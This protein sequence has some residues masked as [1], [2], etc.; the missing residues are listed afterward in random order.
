MLVICDTCTLG[1][2]LIGSDSFAREIVHLQITGKITFALSEDLYKEYNHLPAKLL[3]ENKVTPKQSYKLS[4]F[5]AVTVF[6]ERNMK[7]FF[8]ISD[9][10]K[11][12][13]NDSLDDMLLHLAIESNCPY[14]ITDNYS[15]FF[16]NK[17]KSA[18]T[19]N[20]IAIQIMT[21]YQF[22]FKYSKQLKNAR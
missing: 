18:R 9:Y 8:D 6:R 17:V 1:N 16:Y 15:D 3:S 22:Y 10:G 21:A 19:K 5:M 4:D 13:E 2:G 14:I 11:Y 20:G 12:V 7:K